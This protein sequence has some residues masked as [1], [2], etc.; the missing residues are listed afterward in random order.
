MTI[1]LATW[2][3]VGF[4]DILH[5]KN[6][7]R[8]E[9]TVKQTAEGVWFE[10]MLFQHDEIEKIQKKKMKKPKADKG[11]WFSNVMSG[12]SGNKP[13]QAEEP[14][15][16]MGVKDI[17]QPKMK[18][19]VWTKL[20]MGPAGK[21]D[22]NIGEA[23]NIYQ[24]QMNKS[25]AA[26]EQAQMLQRMANQQ[27]NQMRINMMRAEGM[28]FDEGGGS[29]PKEFRGNDDYYDGDGYDNR[30][31]RNSYRNNTNN[32]TRGYNSSRRYRSRNGKTGSGRGR[33]RKFNINNIG[34]TPEIGPYR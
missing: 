4:A 8:M 26:M 34:Q 23:L 20:L 25:A 3:Q 15:K 19:D 7:N 12:F 11:S 16:R 18:G 28:N 14:K 13:A 6:G 30:N 22:Q 33:T 2:C 21:N 5:L 29:S 32:R 31:D 9:G 10:G 17:P 1:L 24:E 27:Q